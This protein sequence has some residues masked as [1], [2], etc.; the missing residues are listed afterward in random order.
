MDSTVQDSIESTDF[1]FLLVSWDIIFVV[2]G[3]DDF[4]HFM[5]FAGYGG[6]MEGSKGNSSYKV[7]ICR[8][9]IT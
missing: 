4:L 7:I 9:N 2:S 6:M 8:W 5:L 1:F 3:R